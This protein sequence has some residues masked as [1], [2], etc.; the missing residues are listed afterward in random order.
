MTAENRARRL[1]K[2]L[3]MITAKNELAYIIFKTILQK[4]IYN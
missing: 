4:S 3:H 2:I 1:Y